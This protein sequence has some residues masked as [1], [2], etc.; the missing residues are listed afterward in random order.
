MI[1]PEPNCEYNVGDTVESVGGFFVKGIVEKVDGD[2]LTIRWTKDKRRD[3]PI[4]CVQERDSSIVRKVWL[5]FFFEFEY[6]RLGLSGVTKII[7]TF[8]YLITLIITII[9]VK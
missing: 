2:L 5:I 7:T 8:K 9:S 3:E 1:E 4:D 6:D